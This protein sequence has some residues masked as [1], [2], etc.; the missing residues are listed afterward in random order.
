[1]IKATNND[2]S[3]QSGSSYIPV[4]DLYPETGVRSTP[5]V[6][7]LSTVEDGIELW[8]VVH[9]HL[10]VKLEAALAGQDLSPE[11]VEAVGKVRPLLLKNSEA[12]EVSPA[13]GLGVGASFA[14]GLLA[15]V[16]DLQ[17]ED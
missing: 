7:V 4:S 8:I 10:T 9:L 2:Q 15:R 6:Q 1:M 17:G 14:L 16:V 13:V 11:L 5:L 3:E 12:M